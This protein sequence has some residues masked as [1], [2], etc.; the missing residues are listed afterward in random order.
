MRILKQIDNLGKSEQIGL[1][2]TFFKKFILSINMIVE[3][4]P[5]TL[6]LLIKPEYIVIF[7]LF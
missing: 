4:I 2:Y 1:I 7:G 6:S 5:N 3:E